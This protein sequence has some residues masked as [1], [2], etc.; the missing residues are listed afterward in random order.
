M[1]TPE[2]TLKDTLRQREDEIRDL[3]KEIED[4][5]AILDGARVAMPPDFDSL[6]DAEKGRALGLVGR[7][8]QALITWNGCPLK[9]AQGQQ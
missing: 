1:G 3:R 6:T 2:E 5:H 8:S 9:I 4:C 7:L